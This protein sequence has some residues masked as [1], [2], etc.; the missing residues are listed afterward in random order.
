MLFFLGLFV[1]VFLFNVRVVEII[2]N[3]VGKVR[4]DV[5]I[6]WSQG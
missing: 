1:F 3:A 6:E 4:G 5:V 2:V